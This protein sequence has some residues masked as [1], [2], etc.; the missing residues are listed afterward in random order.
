[1]SLPEQLLQNTVRSVGP[2]SRVIASQPKTFTGSEN[3]TRRVIVWPTVYVPFEEVEVTETT[4]G[5]VPFACAVLVPNIEVTKIPTVV[6]ALA[7][8]FMISP[9]S[10]MYLI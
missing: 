8:R 2:V 7:K 3:V 1:V 4:V 5:V 10:H 9:R 6:K